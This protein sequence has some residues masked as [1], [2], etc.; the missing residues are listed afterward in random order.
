MKEIMKKV[1]V[2][3]GVSLSMDDIQN[4]LDGMECVMDKGEFYPTVQDKMTV[5]VKGKI[6]DNKDVTISFEEE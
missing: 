3:S 2:V 1:S 4:N 6:V 5:K